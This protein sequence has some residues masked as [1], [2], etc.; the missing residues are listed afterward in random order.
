[1]NASIADSGLFNIYVEFLKTIRKPF[2]HTELYLESDRG[3]YDME[4]INRTTDLCEFYKTKTFKPLVQLI[5]KSFES[6]LPHWYKSCPV[7][8]VKTLSIDV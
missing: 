6:Y 4:L 7:N 5:L 3:N 2:M 8:K 1:M